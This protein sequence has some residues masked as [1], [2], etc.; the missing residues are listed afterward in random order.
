MPDLGQRPDGARGHEQP[1]DGSQELPCARHRAG[2]PAAGD[3]AGRVGRRRPAHPEG[4]LHPG[5]ADVPRPDPAVSRRH[6]DDRHRVRQLHRGRRLPARHVGSRGD[7]L[8]PVEGVP[9]RSAAGQDG[10]RRGVRRRVARRRGDARSV[11]PGLAD[12][13]ADD[14]QDAIRI[15]RRIVARLNWRKQGP[16]T[17]A[18][19]REAAR[20]RRYS[21]ASS[22][23]A[24]CRRTC[25]F[26]STR[27]R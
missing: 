22:C 21:T 27:A 5:R 10:D 3:L 15:G 2:E 12:Y 16:G 13:L 7:D 23:S 6:P 4:D 24:S 18:S 20:R 1:V 26:R 19:R 8:G 11:R 17:G 25:G 9:R 14:E